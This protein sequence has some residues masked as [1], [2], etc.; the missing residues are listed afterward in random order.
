LGEFLQNMPHPVTLRAKAAGVASGAGRDKF[1]G[2]MSAQRISDRP[3]VGAELSANDA[4]KFAAPS[5]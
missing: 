2:A 3:W 5:N 4:R 1:R